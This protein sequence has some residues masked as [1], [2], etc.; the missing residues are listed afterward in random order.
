MFPQIYRA[1]GKDSNIRYVHQLL[2]TYYDAWYLLHLI[3]HT[4]LVLRKKGLLYMYDLY[5]SF[6]IRVVRQ[7]GITTRNLNRPGSDTSGKKAVSSA[8][9]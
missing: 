9:F 6:Q 2:Q 5:I 8:P 7:V 4:K 3:F 1:G